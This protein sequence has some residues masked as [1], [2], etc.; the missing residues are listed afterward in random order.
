MNPEYPPSQPQEP[1]APTTRRPLRIAA[2]AGLVAAVA[3]GGAAFGATVASRPLPP[4]RPAAAISAKAA[5]A[6]SGP[7]SPSASSSAPAS[8]APA[9]TVI[10]QVPAAPAQPVLTNPEAV[11]DQFYQDIT[12]GDYRAAWALGGDNISGGVG[13]DA[14]VAGY[15]TTSS[16]SLGTEQDLGSD[17]VSA[18]LYATQDDGTVS[19]YSGTY[20]VANGVIVAAEITKD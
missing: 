4:P 16:I 13:Y 17:Q 2:L 11:V 19:V 18:V 10:E 1:S 9:R 12:D 7:A 14:W 15:A 20:T 6:A 5:T 8:P 3:A